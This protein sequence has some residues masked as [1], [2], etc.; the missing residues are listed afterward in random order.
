MKLF[1]LNDLVCNQ[2]N[3]LTLEDIPPKSLGGKP[4]ALT[5]KSCNSKSGHILDNNLLNA[6]LD[7]DLRQFSKSV[8]NSIKLTVND[9]SV[10]AKICSDKKGSFIIETDSKRNNPNTLDQFTKN[11]F[12]TINYDDPLDQSDQIESEKFKIEFFRNYKIDNAYIALLRIAYLLLFAEF[13]NSFLINNNLEDLRSQIL[14]P[15]KKII[16]GPVIIDSSF[17]EYLV[18]IN[19][20]R[21][22]KVLRSFLVI[23]NLDSP[24]QKR[25]FAVMIPGYS[26]PGIKIYN[27]YKQ[28]ILNN[29]TSN[30]INMNI[31]HIDQLDF[32]KSKKLTFASQYIWERIIRA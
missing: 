21:E 31:Y 12:P 22:P 24:S 6:I 28:L 7:A 10:I 19:I 1:N 15:N 11:L 3:C 17:P 18:G 32:L 16:D 14:N 4:K 9:T 25:Q 30:N 27:N 20:I 2:E 29:T 26:D 5:C 8:K 23:F 13:G